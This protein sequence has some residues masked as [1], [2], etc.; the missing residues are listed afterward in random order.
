[1]LG[2]GGAAI[3]HQR[4]CRRARTG[5]TLVLLF[6]V[7]LPLAALPGQ[8]EKKVRNV[9]LMIADG[10]STG[11]Y[12]LARWVNGGGPLAM[13]E[14]VCGLVRT[15]G[16]NTPLTDSAQAAT[17]MATGFKSQTGFIGLL[18][19]AASMH[20]VDP[21]TGTDP[22]MRPLVSV[23]EAARLKGKATGLA[24][25]CEIAHAT[26]AAFSAHQDQRKDFEAIAEQQV[27]N[28][29][30]VVLAG[31]AMYLQAGSRRDGEDLEEV[32]RRSGY[33]LVRNR[34]EMLAH[35][36]GRL[37]GLFAGEDMAYD[38]DRPATEPSLAEMTAKAI[39][40]LQNDPQGFFLLVEGSKIDWAAHDNEPVGVLS[41]VLAFDRAVAVALDFAQRDNDTAVIVLSDHGCG[42]LSIGDRS[43]NSLKEKPGVSV[44]IDPLRRAR[45][46]AEGVEKELLA[47]G[48][49]RDQAIRAVVARDY[50]IDLCPGDLARVQAYFARRRPDQYGLAVILGPILSRA[51]CLGWTT[52]GHTGEDVPLAIFH[53][54]G[55]RLSGVVQNTAI[56][57]YIDEILDLGLAEWNRSLYLPAKKM[58]SARGA[59]TTVSEA[60]PGNLVLTVRKGERSLL[61]PADK[62]LAEMDG[63]TVFLRS[64]VV[65]NG[66]AFFVPG[67]ALDLID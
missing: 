6:A 34:E 31:G 4:S 54:R 63:R 39:A 55:R 41:D 15:Y 40:L 23:L 44:F 35:R 9:I 26:P 8:G 18:P 45:R 60:S 1:M 50:G 58:F 30:D 38:I 53:P 59:V 52:D 11:H 61:L 24:V 20:G 21:Q 7:S 33:R 17:A 42:G 51:A 36:S 10:A 57:W 25:T 5:L 12:A 66:T 14:W 3:I 62:N 22:Q 64:L 46:T 56:A 65:F 27:Y 67:E 43:V 49:F 2:P 37:W 19:P 16:A 32:L 28:G 47:A 13:D 29:I 48:N